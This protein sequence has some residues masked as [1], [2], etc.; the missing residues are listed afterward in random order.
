MLDDREVLEN[1]MA[2]DDVVSLIGYGGM[3]ENVIGRCREVHVADMRPPELLLTTIIGDRIEYAP[4]P[5]TFHGPDEDEAILGR[6]DVAILTASSL[7]N[8]TIDDLLRYSSKARVTG[9]YGPSA[10]VIPDVLFESGVDFVM[11]HRVADPELFRNSLTTEMN[12]ESA[13]RK[14]QKYQTLVPERMVEDGRI[15]K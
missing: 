6:S 1:V 4:S 15:A 7:V 13:I 11:S 9:L 14:H 3:V 5:V 2:P 8:G 12:M 10:S